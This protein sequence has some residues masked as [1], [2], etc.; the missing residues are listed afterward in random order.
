MGNRKKG[1]GGISKRKDGRWEGRVVV[2]YDEKGL[3]KTKNVLAKTKS[4]CIEKLE[5][6]KAECGQK[7]S[8]TIKPDM[9][10][11]DW[12]DYWYRT[13]S[14]PKLRPSTQNGYENMIYKHIIPLLGKKQLNE[15]T[16]SDINKFYKKLK[17]NGRITM[18]TNKNEKSRSSEL[19]DRTVRSCHLC[20]RMALQKAVE[21]RLIPSNP[22][23]DCKLPTKSGR[24]M[25][26]LTK[27]EMQR[28]LIQAKEEG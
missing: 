24:E 15:L 4:E 13:Y 1:S 20:C 25:E 2:S 7:K 26:I 17:T 21:E 16:E 9:L 8:D 18:Q 14:Q 28:F 6:L 23:D 5:K 3:P 12:V 11:G 22:T 19:S 10:F 27:E